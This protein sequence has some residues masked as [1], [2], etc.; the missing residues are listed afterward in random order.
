[1]DGSVERMI[2]S[3]SVLD[4]MAG[5]VTHARYTELFA[6]HPIIITISANK[7]TMHCHKRGHSPQ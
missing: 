5:K 3:A 1:M 4:I 6:H 7:T 2:L